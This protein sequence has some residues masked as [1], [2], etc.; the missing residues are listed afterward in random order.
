MATPPIT[1][2]ADQALLERGDE[3]AILQARMHAVVRDRE[4]ALVFV[5]GEAGA[6]K[7]A[8][9]HR[10]CELHCPPARALSGSCD[11]LAAPRALGPFADVAGVTGGEL[12]DLL[13]RDARPHEM[14]EAFA[15]EVAR[16]RSV[17]VLEDLHWADE[18]TLDLLRLLGRRL[19]GFRAL[20]LATYRDDELAASHP[21]RV[22]V[23]EL[24]R[25]PRTT[26]L[27][28]APLSAAAVAELAAPYGVD[29][30]ELHRTTGGNPFFVVEVLNAGAQEIPATVRDAVLARVAALSDRGRSL[31]EALTV[32]RPGSGL[33]LLAE[34]AGAAF[35]ALD[36]CLGSGVI[37]VSGDGV[38]FR[39][40][41][42]RLVIDESLP[43]HRRS[44]LHSRA[45]RALAAGDERSADLA[46]LAH[47]AE[48]AGDGEAVL[49]YAPRAAEHASAAGAHRES[50]AQYARAL[51]FD[52]SLAAQQ[53]ADLL[54][55]RSYEC[56]LSDQW[57]EAIEALQE[58]ID[59]RAQVGD[60]PAE[61]RAREALSNVLWCP[62]RVAEA[63]DSALRSVALLEGLGPSRE[64]AMAYGRVAQ[65][66]T[67]AEDLEATLTWGDRALDLADKLGESGLARYVAASVG[68]ARL[69]HDDEDG[70]E[71]LQRLLA[72]ALERRRVDDAARVMTLLAWASVRRRDYPAATEH[73]DR[74]V[75]YASRHGSELYRGYLLAHR[76]QA[77]LD[78][79]RWDDAT[80]TAAAVL[81]EPRRS[82]IPRIVTLTVV[83]RI[84][85]RRGDPE[86]WPP[87]EEALLLAARG[88][89]L[90]ADAPVAVARAEAFWLGGDHAAVD[91]ATADA[92]ELARLRRSRWVAAELLVWRRRVGLDDRFGGDEVAGPHAL[93][94]AGDH[95]GAA[96]QWR[97]LGCRY[98]AA[99]AMAGG[100]DED[101]L[102][103]AVEELRGLGARSAHALVARR[104][105]ARGVRG[106]PLG[107][108][109]R[110]LENPSGLTARE[111]EVL[112]LLREGMRNAAIADQLVLSPKTVDHH[113]SAILR[114]LGVSSRGEA[115]AAAARLGLARAP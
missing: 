28:L 26:T 15:T 18:A 37:V 100:D 88:Q 109:R 107:P 61:G 102:R 52:G 65:L 46:R 72:L 25:T 108:R 36:E 54:E 59:L 30:E 45:L 39:H 87:L 7:T 104:L 6:G 56:L 23:G 112:E 83:A 14:L 38:A 40:E 76:A 82:R 55:R 29:G 69:L 75:T 92:L 60:A 58:V 115:A 94:L 64:L 21:L 110:T 89:E 73:L 17:V 99:M 114:K 91:A 96:A 50:A 70:A 86:V 47:H 31:L 90:Q 71:Q 101:A 74:A 34:I 16:T 51:R 48:A 98:D 106:V 67:E 63:R 84:R 103:Q 32:P 49:R 111:L 24:A 42:E 43:P 80:E 19:E 10:F 105:R 13:D 85:A 44:A 68:V 113:V 97:G 22:V 79:G 53:R 62:G 1:P 9:V 77:E 3:L 8:L 66:A 11:A 12:R 93:Q 4:G 20:V 81:R 41:L 78:L 35:G 27:D 95:A 33:H 5:R 57:Q 2:A